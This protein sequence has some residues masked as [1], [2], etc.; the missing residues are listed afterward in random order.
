M[1][2]FTTQ[3]RQDAER[4]LVN[5]TPLTKE[6]IKEIHEDIAKRLPDMWNS[7]ESTVPFYVEYAR[8]IERAHGIGE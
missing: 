8:A 3:D 6:K 5:R 7:G 1:T 2:T 4:E